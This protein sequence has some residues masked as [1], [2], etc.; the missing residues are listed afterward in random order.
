MFLLINSG[1]LNLSLYYF[2]LKCLL[3][4]MLIAKTAT[5]VRIC[6]FV[7]ISVLGSS[8]NDVMV[9]GVNIFVTIVLKT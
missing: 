5:N 1:C 3:Q 2:E 8:I 4:L 6:F 7:D 9:E